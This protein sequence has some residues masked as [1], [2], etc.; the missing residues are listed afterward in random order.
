MTMSAP[1]RA[2][3]I[4]EAHDHQM[5]RPSHHTATKTMP[6]AVAVGPHM[7]ATPPATTR[8][9]DPHMGR[10]KR[11]VT[12]PATAEHTRHVIH[13][14]SAG[15]TY[16]AAGGVSVSRSFH[17]S[18]APITRV[19]MV[20]E[21]GTTPQRVVS[22]SAAAPPNRKYEAT[23]PAVMDRRSQRHREAAHASARPTA[24]PAAAAMAPWPPPNTASKEATGP[25][26]R[27]ARTARDHEGMA[28]GRAD[29]PIVVSCAEERPGRT[30]AAPRERAFT[31]TPPARPASEG[32]PATGSR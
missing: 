3:V 21:V 32:P 9:T 29:A 23:T 31:P 20:R 11:T 22:R 8:A 10:P 17:D 14:T 13:G 5:I 2:L 30:G 24:T 16:E 28:A 1:E 4:A 12:T 19:W 15:P 25:T 18:T 6:G 7:V 27:S 26:N